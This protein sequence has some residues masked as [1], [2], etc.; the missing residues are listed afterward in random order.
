MRIAVERGRGDEA[1]ASSSAS[2][3]STAASRARSRSATSSA[4]TTS[5]ARRSACRSRGSPR[6][7]R[8]SRRRLGLVRLCRRLT[9]GSARERHDEPLVR[10]ERSRLRREVED[11][12][13]L[14]VEVRDQLR[15]RGA[16]ARTCA[17]RRTKTGRRCPRGPTRGTRTASTGAPCRALRRP[18]IRPC[19]RC[20]RGRR[21]PRRRT[22]RRG[23]T[24]VRGCPGRSGLPKP[25]G[26]QTTWTNGFAGIV[27]RTGGSPSARRSRVHRRACR[28]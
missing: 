27:A 28:A 17:I 10:G 4:S 20:R 11:R 24:P 12:A 13:R 19:R 9:A 7:R 14:R 2:A 3:A 21:R 5:A 15:P 6:R 18:S 25:C 23:S 22:G 8:R 1:G 26:F 16:S